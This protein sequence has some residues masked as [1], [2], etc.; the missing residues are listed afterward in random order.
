MVL[1]FATSATAQVTLKP[2]YPDG[3]TTTVVEQ[4]K[5][6]QSL[7]VTV[8]GMEV[9]QVTGGEQTLTVTVVNG[10]RADDGSLIVKAKID[11]IK[12]AVMMPN[13]VELGFDSSDPD[14]DPPGTQFDVILDVFKAMLKSTWTTTLNQ[15]N[16]VVAITGRDA[17]FSELPTDLLNSLKAQ[18]D[19]EYL[20]TVANDEL[21]KLPSTPVKTGDSWERT[22]LVRFEAGQRFTFTTTYKYEGSIEKD[23]KKLEKIVFKVTGVEYDTDA[24]SPLQ[25][26]ESGLEV[27]MSKGLILFDVEVGQ[28]VSQQSKIQLKGP[29]TLELNGTEIPGVLDLTI[30]TNSRV[31]IK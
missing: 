29:L 27:A 17:A 3:R 5:S 15:D 6:S 19:P 8:L 7:K 16:R 4:V 22:N 1:C 10:K 28:I 25:V 21:N 30:E 20:K 31:K 2:K 12:A 14:A 23:G 9:D 24:D 13:G 18:L 26:L 11:A